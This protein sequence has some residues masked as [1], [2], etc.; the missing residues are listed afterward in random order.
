MKVSVQIKSNCYN[1]ISNQ[2]FPIWSLSGNQIF[3]LKV[4]LDKLINDE[5][6]CIEAF[7]LLLFEETSDNL[8]YEYIDF[9]VMHNQPKRLHDITFLQKYK[10]V[11]LTLGI[12]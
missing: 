2:D 5:E 3:E 10:N 6:N 9:S 1:N 11:T 12:E 7:K 8:R 4:D